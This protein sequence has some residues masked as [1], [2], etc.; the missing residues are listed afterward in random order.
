M[1][2]SEG[3]AVK[4][5]SVEDSKGFTM[6]DSYAA[7]KKDGKWGFMDVNGKMVIEPQ[8]EDA[9]SFCN[10][11][12]AIAKDGEWGFINAKGTIVIEP[13]FAETKD[14][15]NGNV[16]VKRGEIWVLLKLYRDNY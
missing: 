15:S 10:G 14:F 4:G 7:V 5:V 6:P 16:Y 12:A 8:F 3:K 11:Y 13:Q 9:R 2:D 1:V